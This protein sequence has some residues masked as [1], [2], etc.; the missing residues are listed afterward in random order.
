[1]RLYVKTNNIFFAQFTI[2]GGNF[3]AGSKTTIG[4]LLVH[5][6]FTNE[7]VLRFPLIGNGNFNTCSFRN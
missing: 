2:T 4:T 5:P 7:Q 6:S 1:M 3:T